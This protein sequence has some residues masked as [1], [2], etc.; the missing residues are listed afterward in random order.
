MSPDISVI[1]IDDRP[2][3]AQAARRLEAATLVLGAARHLESCDVPAA[4][5]RVVLGDVTAALDALAAQ[6]G[7]AVV[8]ASGDPGFFGIVRLLHEQGLECEVFPAAS[9]VS[10]LCA[11]AQIAWDDALVLSA[12]GRGDGGLR[13]AVNACR[14]FPNSGGSPD[15][16]AGRRAARD[17]R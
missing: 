4:A 14:A 6:A 7:N 15:V 10:M 16:D 1:G 9:S 2:L 13:R 5:R 12:H 8:L 11:R 17:G 3:S